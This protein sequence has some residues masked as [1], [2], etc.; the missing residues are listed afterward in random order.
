VNAYHE[1]VEDYAAAVRNN[2]DRMIGDL[3]RQFGLS[4]AQAVFFLP[5]EMRVAAPIVDFE[6][7]WRELCSWERVTFVSANQGAIVEY[8]GALPRGAYGHGMFNLRQEGSALGGHI[9]T[10]L[11]GSIWFVSKPLFGRENH[12]VQFFTRDG[13]AMFSVYVGRGR[14]GKLLQSVLTAYLELRGRYEGVPV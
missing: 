1:V 5:R 9:L 14:D 7:I 8:S 11:L 6:L 12:S 10:A 13:A 3:A 2:P 4:E